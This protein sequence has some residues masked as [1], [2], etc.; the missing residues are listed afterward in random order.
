MARLT[1]TAHALADLQEIHSH[2]A[3]DKPEAARRFTLRLRAKVRQVAET[4]GM[5]RS[6]EDLRPGL[7]SFPIGQYLLFYRAQP[8]GLVLVRVLHGRGDLPA[9][10]RTTEF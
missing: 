3:Q 8:G 2:I 5:G 1:I 4:P 7:F 9:L 6:R 10:F